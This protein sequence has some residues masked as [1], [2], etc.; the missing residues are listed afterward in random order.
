MVHFGYCH[1]VIKYIISDMMGYHCLRV[2]RSR[3][4]RI[5]KHSPSFSV[6]RTRV[7]GCSDA[8]LCRVPIQSTVGAI[9]LQAAEIKNEN[10]DCEVY[11]KPDVLKFT[12]QDTGKFP[13]SNHDDLLDVQYLHLT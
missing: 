9:F 12:P 13:H 7:H 4:R 6:F 5:E 8:E 1:Y 2:V 11:K 10:V 3:D